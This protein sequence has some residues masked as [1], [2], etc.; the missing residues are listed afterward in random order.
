MSKIHTLIEN[1]LSLIIDEL[2][3]QREVGSTYESSELPYD[4]EMEQLREYVGIANEYGIAYE[5]I[6]ATLEKHNFVLSGHSAVRLLEV[7]L[8]MRYKTERTEDSQ[9]DLR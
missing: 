2:V 8:L 5:G 4:D 9:F 1:K 7:G 6:V 3:A